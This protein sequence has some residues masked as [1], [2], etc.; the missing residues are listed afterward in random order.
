[1]THEASKEAVVRNEVLQR[2]EDEEGLYY[3]LGC[4]T[5][6]ALIGWA[7]AIIFFLLWLFS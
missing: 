1:M 3:A 7:L 4:A 5:W 2:T 6:L